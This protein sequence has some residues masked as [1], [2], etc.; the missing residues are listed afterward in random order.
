MPGVEAAVSLLA[1]LIPA[2]ANYYKLVVEIC[3]AKTGH[4]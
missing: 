1:L 3:C 4:T 2:L